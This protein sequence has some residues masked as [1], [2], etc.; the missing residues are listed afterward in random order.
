MG[1]LRGG[2]LTQRKVPPDGADNDPARFGDLGKKILRRHATAFTR[3]SVGAWF[4][5]MIAEKYDALIIFSDFR[6]GFRQYDKTDTLI[7][8]D[9]PRT[10]KDSRTGPDRAWENRWIRTL[11][12]AAVGGA[13]KVHLYSLSVEPQAVW[14]RCAEASGGS[15]TMVPWMRT[16]A[17]PPPED[18]GWEKTVESVNKGKARMG[19]PVRPR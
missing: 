16:A 9:R 15:V 1:L 10:Q 8:D 6:D 7:F 3:G 17:G 14:K 12:K 19:T 5:H 13:P 11:A 4:D 2:R 18:G